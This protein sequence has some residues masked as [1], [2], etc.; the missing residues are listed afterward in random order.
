MALFLLFYGVAAW[1]YPGGSWNDPGQVGFSW[2]HNYLC[3]LLDTR[4][5]NGM[6][7]AGRYWARMSLGFLCL[8]MMVLWYRLP[9]LVGGRTWFRFLL[10]YSG[11]AALGTMAFLRAGTH[12]LTVRIGGVL[13]LLAL[14]SLLLGLWRRHYRALGLMGVWCL[15]CFSLNYA[16]YETGEYLGALPLIQKITFSSFLLWFAW[17]HT[18][19]WREDARKSEGLPASPSFENH[20]NP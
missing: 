13:G 15:G 6:M 20:F 11:L 7:N 17:V 9:L 16:I 1:Y 4:A 19:I 5:V 18:R 3:D 8:G 12:D 10:R 14:G 2:R